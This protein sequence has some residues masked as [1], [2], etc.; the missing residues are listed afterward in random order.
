MQRVCKPAQEGGKILLLEHGRSSSWD[1]LSRILDKGAE[2]HCQEWGCL[3][4]KDIPQIVKA[5]GMELKDSRTFH[6]GTTHLIVGLP[7][8]KGNKGGRLKTDPRPAGPL[9]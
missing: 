9:A 7:N 2:K 3:W 1:Y 8:T 5:S 6:F 4:N